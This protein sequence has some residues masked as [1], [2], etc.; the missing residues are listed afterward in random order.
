[1]NDA[2]EKL[3]GNYP[4]VLVLSVRRFL[5]ILR[6]NSVLTGV[7]QI[8]CDAHEEVV[9]NFGIESIPTVIFLK[10]CSA[11]IGHPWVPGNAY[12]LFRE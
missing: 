8:D 6:G 3:A 2:V 10:V 4:N 5:T 7:L 9:D 12:Y 1:M 11:V